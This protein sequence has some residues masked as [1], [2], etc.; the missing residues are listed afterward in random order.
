MSKR[1]GCHRG[2]NKS[3]NIREILRRLRGDRVTLI[4]TSGEELEHV[5]IKS[6]RRD[7]ILVKSEDRECFYI[8]ICCICAVE[9]KCKCRCTCK[10]D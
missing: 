4:L 3:Q 5:K 9:S 1:H 6:V 2:H 10:G 8:R 7:V